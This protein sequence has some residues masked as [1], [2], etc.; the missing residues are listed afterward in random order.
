MV[1]PSSTGQLDPTPDRLPFSSNEAY[2]EWELGRL[3]RLLTSYTGMQ[4][5][6]STEEEHHELVRELNSTRPMGVAKRRGSVESGIRIPFEELSRRFELSSVEE[7]LL[8]LCLS[9]QLSNPIYRLLVEA[10]GSVLKPHLES[11]FVSEV[12]YP[13][14]AHLTTRSWFHSGSKLLREGLL[15][16]EDPPD[17]GLSTGVLSRPVYAPDYVAQA[18]TGRP[19][20]DDRLAGLAT[21][22]HAGADEPELVSSPEVMASIQMLLNGSEPA[23]DGDAMA[24]G[25]WL[26]QGAK[27]TGKTRLALALANALG[28][29]LLT[30]EVGRLAKGDPIEALV[31]LAAHNAR[32]LGAILHVVRPARLPALDSGLVGCLERAIRVSGPPVILEDRQEHG[33]H[34]EIDAL[35]DFIINVPRPDKRMRHQL[36]K[37]YLGAPDALGEEEIAELASAY[38]LTGGQIRSAVAWAKARASREAEV[39][40]GLPGMAQLHAAADVQV[41][42]RLADFADVRSSDATI[43]DIVLPDYPMD[44]VEELIS[45][46]MHRQ[47]VLTGW[48][49]DGR[50]VSGKG[51]VALFT[52][53][54]GTGKTLCAEILANELDRQLHVVSIPRV[55]SK[56]VGET[57]TNIRDIFIQA[58]ARDSL[59]LFDE[60]DTL[61][62]SRVKIEK[63]QDHYLNMQVNMLLQEIE[64]YEGIVILTT[65][66]EA[67]IDRA[68]ERRILF[69]VE[70]PKPDA[71]NRCLIWQL[72]IPEETPIDEELDF[73]YLAET[74]E[75]TG[76]QIKNAI[77][78]AAYRCAAE[79]HGLV[80]GA[81]EDAAHQQSREAGRLTMAT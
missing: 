2:L 49:F 9:P 41:R 33:S 70:F 60:A 47:R 77:L 1:K 30:L 23:S 29:T 73:D 16:T 56:Y 71:D 10:Q 28:R 22:A 12:M 74:F 6:Q 80:Q 63:S 50:L 13:S 76:G 45:A 42:S 21:L 39:G 55:V 58:R 38:E 64:Q 5:G 24:H 20:I 35:A 44:L 15:L 67:N 18:V 62:S 61:F 4:R 11:G 34:P 25:I 75:L 46:C 54:P 66:F 78:R 79:E 68:F 17:G 14:S 48:G 53:E 7:E 36:W 69:S 3:E 43:D 26:I 32:F 40:S 81:L 31:R 57:E 72:L 27:G 65:N 51:L 59:L 52:G 8:F 19:P 37:S